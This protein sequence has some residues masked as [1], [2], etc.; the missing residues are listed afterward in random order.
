MPRVQWTTTLEDEVCR[1]IEWAKGHRLQYEKEWETA[2]NYML[3]N[4]Y[5]AGWLGIA[6]PIIVNKFWPMVQSAVP[7]LFFQNPY[8][9]VSP[10][11]KWYMGVD[12]MGQPVTLDNEANARNAEAT[13]NDAW[14]GNKLKR[15]TR[16]CIVDAFT[17]AVGWMKVGYGAE[18]GVPPEAIQASFDA[19]I[20]GQMQQSFPGMTPEDMVRLDGKG[21]MLERDH[22]VAP[23]YAFGKRIPPVDVWGDPTGLDIEDFRFLFSRHRKDVRQLESDPMFKNTRNLQPEFEFRDDERGSPTSEVP[24]TYIRGMRSSF[25]DRPSMTGQNDDPVPG[26]WVYEFWDKYR[27]DVYWL[28]RQPDKTGRWRDYRLVRRAGSWPYEEMQGFPYYPLRLNIVNNRF[29]PLTGIQQWLPQ[30]RELNMVRSLKMDHARRMGRKILAEKGALGDEEAINLEDP[31]AYTIVDV[32]AGYIDKIKPLDQGSI[33]PDLYAVEGDIR[34]DIDDAS[35]F[36][37]SPTAQGRAMQPGV[38]ATEAQG[39]FS[40]LGLQASDQ[41]ETVSDWTSEFSEGLFFVTRQFWTAEK[42]ILHTNAMDG[43]EWMQVTQD[44]LRG[45]FAFLVEAGQAKHQSKELRQKNVVDL[46]QLI[47]SP[48]IAPMLG[49]DVIKKFLQMALRTFDIT[50]PEALFEG[51]KEYI[52]PIDRAKLQMQLVKDLMAGGAG[53]PG[54]GMEQGALPPGMPGQPGPGPE[55]GFQPNQNGGGMMMPQTG[56][57]AENLGQMLQSIQRGGGRA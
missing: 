48:A 19:E 1:Q 10:R 23:G 36:M 5:D 49:P 3:G 34:R 17:H 31:S 13:I 45:H 18:M 38:T 27:R 12:R 24:G 46:M 39:V 54:Q 33:P 4:Q 32:N 47:M 7:A 44:G 20:M 6:D 8:I 21:R 43:K 57:G 28:V 29:Y 51:A 37:G 2:I 26:V 14:K 35:G 30:Q 56:G 50:M 16:K 15:E 22:R 40:S 41:L 11:E 42:M 25:S 55:Q 52:P 53:G 9:H